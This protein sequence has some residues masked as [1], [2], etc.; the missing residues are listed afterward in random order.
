MAYSSYLN[1]LEYLWDK[2]Q[3]RVNTTTQPNKDSLRHTIQQKWDWLSKAMVLH[4]YCMFRPWLE[5][6]AAARLN[7]KRTSLNNF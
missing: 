7:L 1:P 5:K 3:A 6:V 4:D 2:K